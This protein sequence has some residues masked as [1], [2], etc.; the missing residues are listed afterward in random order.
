MGGFTLYDKHGTPLR[1]LEYSELETL[2]EA[3]KI[4]WPSITEEEI[5]DRSKG[6]YLSKGIVAVQMGWFFTQFFARGEYGLGVTGLELVTLI[7]IWTTAT[8]YILWWFKP[9]DVRCSVPVYLLENA[10]L[11][12]EG[13]LSGSPAANPLS[14]LAHLST[15]R[16]P[17]DSTEGLESTQVHVASQFL[18]SE[19]SQPL[20]QP[21]TV[22]K[23]NPDPSPRG[24]NPSN[25]TEL[26]SHNNSTAAND[27]RVQMY[28]SVASKHKQHGILML[29]VVT[30]F[31]AL[32]DA[33]SSHTLD[34]SMPLCVPTFY[35]PK[36]DDTKLD[37]AVSAG[38]EV[39]AFPFSGLCFL[40]ASFDVR[41]SPLPSNQEG[42]ALRASAI[43]ILI[44]GLLIPIFALPALPST[45]LLRG[46]RFINIAIY[47][48]AKVT[49]L[50][51]A[52]IELRALSSAKLVGIKWTSFSPHI[53]RVH[54]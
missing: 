32:I 9:L 10:N 44:T 3:G 49:L 1:I 30:F 29:P 45:R 11:G 27:L 12:S 33:V 48:I 24:P 34:H 16:E 4:A 28:R 41:L 51:L 39:I 52:C 20:Q 7:F 43:A 21:L 31:T 50:I 46:S 25:A 22:S 14:D 23:L 53:G 15:S 8:V 42:A 47:L 26:P 2:S 54:N 18:I 6:D 37:A 36:V 40:L 13:I 38:Y 35:S 19:E 17:V 5:Q